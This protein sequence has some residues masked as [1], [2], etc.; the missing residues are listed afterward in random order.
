M[1]KQKLET[2]AKNT[3][4]T[5]D[6]T[7]EQLMYL[8]TMMTPSSYLLKHHKVKNHPLTFHISNRNSEKAISHRPWQVGKRFAHVKPY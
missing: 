7:K 1:D 6:V 5:K 8:L 4:G 3:F 2:V